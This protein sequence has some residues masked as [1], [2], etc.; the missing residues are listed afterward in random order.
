MNRA[1]DSIA[2]SKDTKPIRGWSTKV[3]MGMTWKGEMKV[4]YDSP[5]TSEVK[6]HLGEVNPR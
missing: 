1:Y 2:Q 6:S 3:I 4:I 5:N